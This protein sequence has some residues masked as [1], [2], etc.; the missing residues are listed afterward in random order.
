VRTNALQALNSAL[1]QVFKLIYRIRNHKLATTS[2]SLNRLGTSYA[3]AGN[4]ASTAG[5]QIGNAGMAQMQAITVATNTANN[6]M[7]NFGIQAGLAARR[8]SAF[9]IAGGAI[10]TFVNQIRSAVGEALSFQREMVKLGQIGNSTQGDLAGLES[11]VTRLSTT[12]GVSSKDLLGVTVQ[13]RQAG[14]SAMDTKI[15]L[16][17]LAKS[18]LAPSFGNLQDT[19][20][21]LISSMNQ[22]KISAKDTEKT[23]GAINAVSTQYAV[24]SKDIIDAIRRTGGAFKVAG[25]DINQLIAMLVDY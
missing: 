5:S 15:A 12:W 14:L 22:F 7:E 20:D 11:T 18:A 23:L 1:T 10:V 24:S 2:S 9:L 19:T 16:E 13:L 17:A 21:G 3:Q 8:Y 4:A 25:G 6:A